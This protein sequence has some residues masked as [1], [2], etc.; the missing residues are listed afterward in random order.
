VVG[1]SFCQAFWLL[2]GDFVFICENL[3]IK[4]E[5]CVLLS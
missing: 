4:K 1:A 3:R 2:L 5:I